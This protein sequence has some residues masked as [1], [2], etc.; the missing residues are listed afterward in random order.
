MTAYSYD[1]WNALSQDEQSR[2]HGISIPRDHPANNPNRGVYWSG[3][4]AASAMA[5]HIQDTLTGDDRPA[6]ERMFRTLQA[7][8]DRA[9]QSPR[10]V[11]KAMLVRQIDAHR[12]LG[13]SNFSFDDAQMEQLQSTIDD[14]YGLQEKA[15]IAGL[16]QV[17]VAEVLITRAVAQAVGFAPS[18][19]ANHPDIQAF[20]ADRDVATDVGNLTQSVG[21]LYSLIRTG[22]IDALDL[23]G[24]DMEEPRDR[25]EELEFMKDIVLSVP[26]IRDPE[27][28]VPETNFSVRMDTKEEANTMESIV[29]WAGQQEELPAPEMVHRA[30]NSWRDSGVTTSPFAARDGASLGLIVGNTDVATNLL[31]GIVAD[32]A[33]DANIVVLTSQNDRIGAEIAGRPVVAATVHAGIDGVRLDTGADPLPRG[34]VIALNLT[35]EQTN[36]P[37]ERSLAA[38]AFVGSVSSIG[39]LAGNNMAVH[40]AQAIHIAGTARKLSLATNGNGH[41]LDHEGLRKLREQA[42]DL[43]RDTDPNRYF[44]AGQARPFQGI[45]AVAFEAARNFDA[46][47]RKFGGGKDIMGDMYSRI[48]NDAAILTMDNS[49]NAAYKWLNANMQNRGVLYAEATRSL[50]FTQIAGAGMEGEKMM[51][52]EATTEFALYDRPA[53]ER[54]YKI[55]GEGPTARRVCTTPQIDWND[56]RVAGSLILVSGNA[57]GSAQNS[58]A[59]ATKVAQEAIMDRAHTAIIMNDFGTDFHAAHMIMLAEAMGKR[60]TV[61]D[62]TGAEVPLADAR[63][64]TRQHAQTLTEVDSFVLGKRLHGSL[65]GLAVTSSERQIAEQNRRN[66]AYAL[67]EDVGQMT[68]ARLPGMDAD[69]AS[70]LAGLDFTLDELRSGPDKETQQLLY[71]SGMPSETVK[72]LHD[73]KAWLKASENALLNAIAADRLGGAVFQPANSSDAL[74]A[75]SAGFTYGDKPNMPVAAFIG[76]SVKTYDGISKDP[77]DPADLID[78]VALRKILTEMTAK[79]F[80]IGTTMEEGI[81]RAIMEEASEIKGANVVVATSGNPMASSPE[82][83][84]LLGKLDE[85]GKVFVVMPDHIAATSVPAGKDSSMFVDKYAENRDTMYNNLAHNATVGIVV[86]SSDRDQAMH[87]VDRINKL[88]KPVAAMIPQ[89]IEN[90]KQD[91]FAGNLKML[92]GSNKTYIQSINQAE[93]TIAQGYA[94]ID[95]QDTKVELVDGVMRGNAGTFT[96]ARLA[97]N[98]MMRSGYQYREMGWGQAAQTISTPESAGRFAEAV[99]EGRV[100]PLGQYVPM[101]AREMEKRSI[102]RNVVSNSE[103]LEEFKGM[104]KVYAGQIAAEAGNAI[105]R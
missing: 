9:T 60:S 19:L 33:P 32:S 86:A 26:L 92:R 61:V 42:R 35:N 91:L 1:E 69:K 83:R 31:E 76:S 56:K 104:S 74:P 53:K 44:T 20:I 70:K 12:A 41:T 79:G 102:E 4:T 51:S 6:A 2:S 65:E 40:E 43:D 99:L 88:D 5:T 10:A 59:Q 27:P 85:N 89:N 30:F 48:P 28:I 15:K 11:K 73:Q 57:Q 66:S 34:A 82:L 87:I 81:P 36:D 94:K 62:K 72:N 3:V 93:A 47:Q 78:R 21:Q 90:A 75:G 46:A 49:N 105:G 18:N 103:V 7:L 63:D 54:S 95:D 67:G 29:R 77:V 16:D 68:L 58:V 39:H 55:E 14:V 71:K 96:S 25:A 101:T 13:S 50:S 97:R 84:M 100:E 80:A 22:E 17:E 37:V 64:M 45:N 24:Q 8:N 38:N 98:D 23:V 52:R